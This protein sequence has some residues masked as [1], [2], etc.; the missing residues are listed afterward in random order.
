[1]NNMII[2]YQYLYMLLKTSNFAFS[3][4][5]EIFLPKSK[6]KT[7]VKHAPSDNKSE[8]KKYATAT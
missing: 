1:M 5:V 7:S 2:S 8:K 6:L 4:Q 3:Q